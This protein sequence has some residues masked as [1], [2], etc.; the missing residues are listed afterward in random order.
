MQIIRNPAKARP[1]SKNVKR[2]MMMARE[3]NPDVQMIE[4]PFTDREM[5]FCHYQG[6]VFVRGMEKGYG[7]SDFS[8]L[9]MTSQLAA[10][11]DYYFFRP[12]E[13]GRIPSIVG[14]TF[15]VISEGRLL[16]D[17]KIPV[18]M[19]SPDMIVDILYEIDHI[20]AG[21]AK[22][23]DAVETFLKE[24]NKNG[25]FSIEHADLVDVEED[26][27]AYAYWLGYI[28]RFE[29]LMHE[30]SSRMV[31]GAFSEKFMRKAYKTL[32]HN[33]EDA[34]DIC[35][36]LDRMLLHCEKLVSIAEV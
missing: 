36:E 20:M 11:I 1:L 22:G 18:L 31:Y 19:E 2:L 23:E 17:V 12:E 8:S 26:D 15:S 34:L 24:Q 32:S 9:Y 30:E 14:N 5:T 27:K 4:R 13:N 21:L 16:N 10:V 6:N 33:T 25:F 28:Y 29:C 35:R 7:L 3:T